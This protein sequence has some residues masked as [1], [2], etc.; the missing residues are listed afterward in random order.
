MRS[1]PSIRLITD[2]QGRHNWDD[3]VGSNAEAAGEP[4]TSGK[5]SA[6]I[7]GIEIKSGEIIL[8]DQR[9]KQR[10]ALHEFSLQAKG[11][12]SGKPFDLKSAF[13]LEQ[14]EATE[15]R[16]LCRSLNFELSYQRDQKLKSQF[17]LL[18]VK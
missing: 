15:D 8:E 5:V 3:L 1:T 6:T 16:D 2:A 9:D 17:Y 11:I 13:T 4:A 7:A 14:N 12:G 10:M 18:Y